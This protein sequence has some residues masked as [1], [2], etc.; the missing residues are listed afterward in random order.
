[1]RKLVHLMIAVGVLLTFT[2]SA[3]AQDDTGALPP[4]DENMRM[5]DWFLGEWN[6]TS[7]VLIDPENDEWLE[8]ELHTVH[9]SEMGGHIIFEHFFGPLGGEPFEAWSI[10]KYNADTGRWQQRWM[11]TSTAPILT[12][13][14]TFNEDGEYVGYNESYL[15]SEFNLAGERGARE[16]FYNITDDSFDWRYETTSDGG[17]TWTVTWTLEY[18]RA[19]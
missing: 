15:D 9:T 10:R 7:R 11:D 13:G 19:E 8:E 16:I 17:D 14:G 2:A 5:F 4:P 6:V 18:V 12:W 1:M 3:S